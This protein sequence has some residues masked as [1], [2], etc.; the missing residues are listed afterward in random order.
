GAAGVI[1]APKAFFDRVHAAPQAAGALLIL[2]EATCF[3][4]STGGAQKALGTDADLSVLGKLVTGGFPGAAVG[5]RAEL[6][7]MR[8]PRK[9]ILSISG[10][11]SGSPVSMAA[12]YA[13]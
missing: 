11:F 2:D 12:G 6:M 1:S 9:P 8:D 5:G 10:R 13:C 4:L 7:D 3:R